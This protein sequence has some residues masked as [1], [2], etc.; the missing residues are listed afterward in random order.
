MQQKLAR[1]ICCA[2]IVALALPMLLSATAPQVVAE[3]EKN[4]E[5]PSAVSASSGFDSMIAD[6]ETDPDVNMDGWTYSEQDTGGTILLIRAT[7]M[8]KNGSYNWR[9]DSGIGSGADD[10]G[11]ISKTFDL[12]NIDV[13]RVWV[14]LYRG[15]GGAAIKGS[16][17]IGGTEK[18]SHT[19]P[20]GATE[21]TIDVSNLSGNQSVVFKYGPVSSGYH[22]YMSIDYLLATNYFRAIY[23]IDD[24]T[25]TKWRP[26]PA[27]ETDAWMTWDT[28]NMKLLTGCRIYWG[29]DA[30]YRPTAYRIQT[31]SDNS[32]WA[33]VIT[34]TEAPPASAWKEYSWDMAEKRYIKL[35]VDTHGSS[36]TEIYEM[37]Y[38]AGSTPN[39]PTGLL[40]EGMTN[41]TH[42]LDHTPEFSAIG[43]D[44][45]SG[46]NFSYYRIQVDDTSDFSSLIWDSGK[47]SITTFENGVRCG[48]IE[49]SGSALSEGIIYYW[50]IKFWDYNDLEGD[51]SSETAT[52]V[53]NHTPAIVSITVN[54]PLVDRDLD[55]S[56]SGAVLTTTITI[57]V[58]DDDGYGEIQPIRFWIRDGN[59]SVVVDNVQITDNTVVDATTLNFV[60]TYNPADELSDSALGVFDVKVVAEDI[61]GASDSNDWAGDGAAIFTVD[62]GT[63]TMNFDPTSPYIGNNLTVYGTISRI[64]G[65][66]SADNAWLIDENHGTFVQG[67]GNSWSET[68]TIDK[69]QRGENVLVLLRIKDYPLDGQVESSYLVNPDLKFQIE[70]R[71]EENGELIENLD[72]HDYKIKFWW[73]KDDTQES[74]LQD[75]T[76]NPENFDVECGGD[77]VFLV[78]VYDNN[79]VSLWRSRVPTVQGGTLVFLMPS[80]N[81][82]INQYTFTIEDYTQVFYDG[83]TRFYT[84]TGIVNEDWWDV[85]FNSYAYLAL[86]G[87]YKIRLFSRDGTKQYDFGHFQAESDTTPP[88]W[89]VKHFDV[90]GGII[91][92]YDIISVVG[93]RDENT[94]YVK[95]DWTC[96]DENTTLVSIRVYDAFKESIVDEDE[97]AY[98]TT[99][100]FTWDES[101]NDSGYWVEVQTQHE[102]FGTW[103]EWFS[104]GE[105]I[106]WGPG[107]PDMGGTGSPIPLAVL[108][109]IGIVAATAMCFK[110]DFVGAAMIG[111][112]TMVAFLK[113][114]GMVMGIEII[115]VGDEVIIF[116]FVIGILWNIGEAT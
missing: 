3:L 57:R 78:R 47:T 19:G 67:G 106:P 55:Y 95:A 44:N 41:P 103:S 64:V 77:D 97:Y 13:L 61:W 46:D 16:I 17:I 12:T 73:D 18:W 107:L 34:E 68:Y 85:S 116:M 113:Y 29:A 24:S 39:P 94:G 31:S 48:D 65:S 89:V 111:I 20:M 50:R 1:G 115:P 99:V 25:S 86:H 112:P 45:D 102:I 4:W 23:A 100:W 5:T 104:L 98:P 21:V 74:Q 105:V 52:F 27:N 7:D 114:A 35:I 38:N 51:W 70:L 10:Y 109:G 8:V 43:T 88:T 2:L 72:P 15:G 54:N 9:I 28:G 83:W 53:L 110:A 71:F 92:K 26:V 22:T 101:D 37:D 75:I 14:F 49:Y 108:G 76:T 62:D 69:A 81:T 56:G 36:G 66:A 40:S 32:S 80:E 33:T 6:F 42:V 96:Q 90:E 79:P 60:Y 11:E 93:Y 84:G 63:S 59:D 91:Y 30:A 82:T 58:Q 87:Y